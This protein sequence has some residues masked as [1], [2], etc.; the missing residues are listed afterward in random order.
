MSRAPQPSQRVLER[1]ESVR[2]RSG[3][4]YPRANPVRGPE[5]RGGLERARLESGLAL[6]AEEPEAQLVD[7]KPGAPLGGPSLAVD[8]VAHDRVAQVVHVGPDLVR[9][10]GYHPAVHE[11]VRLLGLWAL[12]LGDDLPDGDG[13]LALRAHPD[14]LLRLIPAG[15]DRGSALPAVRGEGA[16]NEGDIVLQHTE[17]DLSFGMLVASES[18]PHQEGPR[19]VH[20]EP[21]GHPPVARLVARGV[22]GGVGAEPQQEP[23][24]EGRHN[25]VAHQV[26]HLG[27]PGQP[28]QLRPPVWMSGMGTESMGTLPKNNN[29]GSG[30]CWAGDLSRMDNDTDSELFRM[31]RRCC[32]P[33]Y[34]ICP[35]PF[36][37]HRTWGRA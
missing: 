9:L 2:E 37:S 34:R 12:V 16:V 35:Y 31:S 6:D 36:R 28:R 29:S 18:L 21:V 7:E 4:D 8:G 20:V 30:R 23:R 32:R 14:A 13:G 27:S 24:L 22:A 3:T 11:G 17:H 26:A 25:G 15:V 19:H 1:S 5:V 10:Q 33:S